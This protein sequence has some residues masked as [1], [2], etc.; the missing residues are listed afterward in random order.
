MVASVMSGNINEVQTK[1]KQHY[2]NTKYVQCYAHQLNLVITN[3]DSI[4][5]NVRIF[6]L[7]LE[8]IVYFVPRFLKERMFWTKSFKDVYLEQFIQDGIFILEK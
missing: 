7:V 1:I 8:G 5:R 3:S 4:N 6:L 2:Q